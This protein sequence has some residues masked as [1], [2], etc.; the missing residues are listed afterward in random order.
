[1]DYDGRQLRVLV[2][3]G[4]Y[5]SEQ[6]SG[7]NEV[8]D[9]EV[10]LL[11]EYGCHV[12]YVELRS[13]DIEHWPAWKRATLPGR[14]VWSRAGQAVVHRAIERSRPD[15]VHIHNTFP[16][17]SPAVFRTAHRSGAGVVHTLHNF[18][19]LCP[20]GT[21]LRDQKPCEEC[22]GRFPLPSIKYGCY[23]DSRLAT[24]PVAVM[25]GLHDR[26]RTWHRYI[27]RIIV[28]SAYEREKYIDAGWP[29]SKIKVKYNTV[30]D[31]DLPPRR[32]GRHF[33]SLSRLTPEKGVDVLL[34]GWHRAFPSGS[35]PLL[36]TG[37]VEESGAELRAKYGHLPGLTFLGQVER[38]Q[39][40][41]SLVTASAL[42]VPSRCYEG[43]PRVVAEA[44]AV[45]VPVVASRVGSLVEL[46]VEDETG[47]QVQVD[48]PDDMARALRR[49]ADSEE[50]CVRL[51]HGARDRYERLYSP[52][53]TMRELVGIYRDAIA[54]RRHT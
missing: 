30:R 15:V 39:V 37:G 52:E 5:R 33:L 32:T 20:A 26:L 43:F 44:Y 2:V 34:E 25:D 11:G 31:Q 42:I 8:V 6:Q 18:R 40:Y 16:L 50:L 9:D 21:F 28:V 10:R 54:A 46:I 53:V 1:M 41:E 27:D 17:F 23:R 29:A 35:P 47:L 22:F 24:V 4:R 12:D 3:H 14:V 7:E 49:L 45:G 51:G 13:D 19:P 38:S 36:L 48:D